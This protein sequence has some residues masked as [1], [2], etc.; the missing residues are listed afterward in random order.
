MVPVTTSL[1]PK[2]VHAVRCSPASHV[3][4]LKK[5][6]TLQTLV[7]NVRHNDDVQ[8]RLR[9]NTSMC[10]ATSY[11][12]SFSTSTTSPYVHNDALS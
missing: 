6:V 5:D 1:Q 9:K 4:P 7:R 3:L 10:T 8:M 12:S 2:V 11:I